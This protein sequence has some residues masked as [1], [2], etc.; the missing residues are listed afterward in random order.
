MP[1]RQPDNP[2][3]IKNPCVL[4][5]WQNICSY[6]LNKNT[7][8]PTSPSGEHHSNSTNAE[9][10]YIS[11]FS[12][13]DH[14]AFCWGV[15]GALISPPSAALWSWLCSAPAGCEA[16]CCFSGAPPVRHSGISLGQPVS[17]SE[18]LLC[19]SDL[20]SA[21]YSCRKPKPHHTQILCTELPFWKTNTSL[22]LL[23]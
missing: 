22:V 11:G 23:E 13:N 1:C 4:T 20:Y 14:N 12:K 2:S 17:S 15:K 18:P 6:M 21:S 19:C 16:G 7:K 9:L 5:L 3:C 8:R 10:I